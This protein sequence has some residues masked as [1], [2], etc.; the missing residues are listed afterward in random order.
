MKRKIKR[1]MNIR[2]VC[3]EKTQQLISALAITLKVAILGVL[4]SLTTWFYTSPA[5]ATSTSYKRQYT[6][7]S[8]R[9]LAQRA[10]SARNTLCG[11]TKIEGFV[12]DRDSQD[13]IIIGQ[14]SR[15]Y[16]GYHLDD[17][18]VNI[19]TI[20]N[21]KEALYCSLDPQPKHVRR[22]AQI[23]AEHANV[24]SPEDRKRVIQQ[25]KNNPVPQSVRIGGI[26]RKS[27]HA[28]IMIEADYHMKKVSLGLIKIAGIS[29]YLEL[30]ARQGHHMPGAESSF[31]RFW[32]HIKEGYPTFKKSR[33][34]VWLDKSPVILLTAKESASES[35]VLYDA[36]EDDP[37]AVAFAEN[38]SDQF[39]RAATKVPSYAR[40]EN[41][42]RLR[43]LLMVMNSMG[44]DTKAGLEMGFYLKKY[45]YQ[46]E[47]SMPDS[48]PG[49]VNYKETYFEVGDGSKKWSFPMVSG[50][51]NMEMGITEAQ[52]EEDARLI[53]VSEAVK[54]DR[55]NSDAMTW[56][57]SSR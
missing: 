32:F 34:I 55:P 23:L 43:A 49:L 16:S 6:A 8:M 51:V 36:M 28:H 35:G 14:R 21:K 47:R 5:A 19:R 46:K 10:L 3:S 41:L 25:V 20:W 17:L 56:K 15:K 11:I 31:N 42:Y 44:A 33:D 57:F 30:T 4:L 27:R 54:R 22:V 37:Q 53:K 12:V 50:G 18:V 38:F 48:F 52:F 13:I 1:I 40:L 24:T 9:V 7:V 39:K 26:P 2:S 29:S 45:R